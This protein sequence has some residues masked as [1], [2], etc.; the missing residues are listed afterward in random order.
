MPNKI[1]RFLQGIIPHTSAQHHLAEVEQSMY[2]APFV[3]SKPTL[4]N[5]E[6]TLHWGVVLTIIETMNAIIYLFTCQNMARY[7]RFV[8]CVL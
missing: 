4:R 3:Q 5:K 6:T 2:E 1:R 8:P 7:S